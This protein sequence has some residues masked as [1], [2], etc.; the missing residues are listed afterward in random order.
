MLESLWDIGLANK[1]LK[2]IE[3][4]QIKNRKKS[5]TTKNSFYID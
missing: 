2:Q 3:K 1:T 5:T 4:A